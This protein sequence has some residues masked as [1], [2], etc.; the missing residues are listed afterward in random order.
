MEYFP[1]II[2]SHLVVF[3]YDSTIVSYFPSSYIPHKQNVVLRRPRP[4]GPVG[5]VHW[6]HRPSVQLLQERLR[7]GGANGRRYLAIFRFFRAP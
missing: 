6:V 7:P 5:P 3:H 2:N 1:S 4:R